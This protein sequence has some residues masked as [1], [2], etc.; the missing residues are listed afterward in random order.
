[1]R[2]FTISSSVQEGATVET[3]EIKSANTKIPVLQ[4]GENGRG[5]ELSS[6]PVQLL[7]ADFAKWQAGERVSIFHCTL[8]ETKSG[9]PKI[10]QTL[11]S[12]DHNQA[13]VVL[14][15]PI[16][17]RGGN[18]HT[19]GRADD[20]TEE[21]PKYLPF[22]AKILASG[23]IAQGTAGAMGSGSQYVAIVPAKTIFRTRIS[24]RLYGA[25]GT[26]YHNFD[27]AKISRYTTQEIEMLDYV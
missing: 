2:V 12:T 6:V 9:K 19:G 13:L 21:N 1:M 24:G 25:E 4:V 15:T 16:G 11:G 17:F 10:I 20:W 18:S 3:L 22:P 27:G 26:H 7:P 8:G 14:K 5:R 23:Q